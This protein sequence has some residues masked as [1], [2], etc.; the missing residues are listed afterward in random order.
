[1]KSAGQRSERAR[2][3]EI[4][5]QALGDPQSTAVDAD[6]GYVAAGDSVAHGAQQACIQRFCIWV[7][8]HPEAD[9]GEPVWDRYCLRIIAAASAS[10]AGRPVRAA[11]SPRT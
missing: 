2:Q 8:V 11:R 6:Q 7:R 9:G 1:M 10:S 3:P 5:V 4:A